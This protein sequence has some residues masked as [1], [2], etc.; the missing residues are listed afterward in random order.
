MSYDGEQRIVI[1]RSA[2]ESTIGQRVRTILKWKEGRVSSRTVT[3]DYVVG[4]GQ[5]RPFRFQELDQVVTLPWKSDST[6]SASIQIRLLLSASI[7]EARKALDD[8]R[9]K[10]RT[11]SRKI[12][13]TTHDEGIHHENALEILTSDPKDIDVDAAE[14][15]AGRLAQVFMQLRRVVKRADKTGEAVVLAMRT[16]SA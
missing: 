13:M 15:S 6:A 10:P 9:K 3:L 16:R 1:A 2:D 14:S 12:A 8:L 4:F 5:T 11:L 7:S